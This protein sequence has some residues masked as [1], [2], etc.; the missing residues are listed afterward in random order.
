MN[1]LLQ[2]YRAPYNKKRPV[3]G[4]I[5]YCHWK[6]I[7]LFKLSNVRYKLW[8]DRKIMLNYDSF[9]SMWIM[10][11]YIVDW[12]EFNLI[13]RYIR[14]GDDVF[15][16][17]A[18]M[19]FYTVW[20]SKFVGQGRIHSMEPDNTNFKRL[21]KNIQLNKAEDIVIAHNKAVSDVAGHI[22]FSTG[23]DGENHILDQG[24]KE[25]VVIE[26]IILDDYAKTFT[27]NIAYMKID[28]EGFEYAV[29]N[30]AKNLLTQKKI[31]IIQLE[32]NES[33]KHSGKTIDNVVSLLAD[34][35]YHLHLYDVK[36]NELFP[37][38]YSPARENYFAVSDTLKINGRLNELKKDPL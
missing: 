12:E 6:L 37:T 25:A 28:V 32:L 22:Y 38:I 11:N 23:L 29:L 9:Q 13:S 1:S 31:D 2:F 4:L 27:G 10:Y 14:P 36:K 26:S 33:S 8:N 18:N 35:G 17:G 24:A 3:F 19:G 34:H 7:R 16:I 5:R 30:G 20:M 21:T 15:D